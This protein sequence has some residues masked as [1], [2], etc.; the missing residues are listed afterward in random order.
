MVKKAIENC[1][2]YIHLDHLEVP[3]IAMYRKEYVTPLLRA[4]PEEWIKEREEGRPPPP[5]K[6]R[7]WDL[8]WAVQVRPP[9]SDR[10]S[11][12]VI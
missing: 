7:R 12:R 6:I 11:D 1:L 3:F 5:G 9:P 2:R 10:A 8:L 4:R